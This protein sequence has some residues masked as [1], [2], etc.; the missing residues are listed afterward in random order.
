[1]LFANKY[2]VIKRKNYKILHVINNKKNN[3]Y[4]KRSQ[5]VLRKEKKL[6]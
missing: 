3:V 6:L 1:M 2:N 5:W 4:I